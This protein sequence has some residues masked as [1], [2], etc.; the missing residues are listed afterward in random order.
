MNG[1]MR[2]GT[3]EEEKKRID[4]SFGKGRFGI[5]GWRACVPDSQGVGGVRVAS[6]GERGIGGCLGLREGRDAGRDVGVGFYAVSYFVFIKGAA[7]SIGLFEGH[8]N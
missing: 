1:W 7:A 5:V 4:A 3:R 2:T 6:L 8:G